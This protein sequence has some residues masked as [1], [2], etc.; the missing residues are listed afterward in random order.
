VIAVEGIKTEPQYFAIFNN[1][2]SVIWVNC[3]KGNH[4]S[5]PPQIL[6]RM[7]NYLKRE[8]L[9]SSDEAWLVV[10]KDQWTNDQLEQ[11]NSLPY[12]NQGNS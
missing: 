4:D 12:K 1:Q 7:E 8:A 3:L 6:K 2:K 5:S 10:D 9:K 11:L